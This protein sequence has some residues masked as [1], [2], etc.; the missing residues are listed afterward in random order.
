MQSKIHKRIGAL[1]LS[2]ALCLGL[3]PTAALAA[4]AAAVEDIWDG[5]SDTNWYNDNETEFT[6]T[7]AEELA[8]LAALV[9]KGNT[10]ENKTVKLG[11]NINLSGSE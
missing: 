11:G 9:N 3:L 5:T 4:N 8:G 2:L 7:T 6:L 10:F 1:F